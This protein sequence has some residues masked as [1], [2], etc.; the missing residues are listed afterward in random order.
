MYKVQLFTNYASGNRL[1]GGYLTVADSVKININLLKTKNGGMFV[2]FPSY[3]NKAGEWVNYVNTVSKEANE[4]LTRAVVAEYEKITG[5][6]S[7][8]NPED[9]R[10]DYSSS[11]EERKSP[12]QPEPIKS[13]GGVPSG[14]PF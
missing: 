4:E 14:R 3:Q 12:T 10:V 13:S 5:T 2:S 11:Y 1:A 7:R 6:G 9:R 8:D